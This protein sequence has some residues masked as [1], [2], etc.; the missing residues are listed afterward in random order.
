MVGSWE[1]VLTKEQIQRVIDTNRSGMERLGYLDAEG[2]LVMTQIV[3][4]C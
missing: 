4:E 1:G 2:Q 3:T